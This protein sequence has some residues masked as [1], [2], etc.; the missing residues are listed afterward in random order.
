MYSPGV[1]S[2]YPIESR[3]IDGEYSPGYD[4]RAKQTA[5]PGPPAVGDIP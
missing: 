4:N 1:A 3:R 2:R 5:V